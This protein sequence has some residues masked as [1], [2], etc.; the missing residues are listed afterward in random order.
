MT[1]K[2]LP[3]P[4]TFSKPFWDGAKRDELLIQKCSHCGELLMYPK[5][6]CPACMSEELSF[7][8]A[9]GT[10][11]ILSYTVTKNNPYSGLADELPL[12]TAIVMLD[13]G[14]QMCTKIVDT[15]EEDL[16]VGAPVQVVF[17]HVDDEHTLVNFKQC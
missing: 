15:P 5:R 16:A 2:P 6:F 4:T 7:I 12:T 13:E 10:G 9:A 11:T 8:P 1:S 14:V 3:T 17:E